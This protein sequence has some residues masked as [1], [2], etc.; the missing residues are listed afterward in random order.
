VCDPGVKIN[1]VYYCDNTLK[2]GLLPDIRCLSNDDFPFQ[3][4]RAPA[5]RSRYS[6]AYLRSHVP[7][8]TEPQ[9][10]PP[11]S[12]DLNPVDYSV[13]SIAT[14]SVLYEGQQINKL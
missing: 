4:D 14:D 3:Q 5:Y 8:F 12:Q 1:S 7:E 11:N 6:I 2:Q 9:N 10:W 13:W